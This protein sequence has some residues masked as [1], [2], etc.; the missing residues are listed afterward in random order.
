MRGNKYIHTY[1]RSG[2]DK[3]LTEYSRYTYNFASQ[4]KVITNIRVEFFSLNCPVTTG[5]CLDI[6]CVKKLSNLVWITGDMHN[7]KQWL[8]K[9]LKEGYSVHL[10]FV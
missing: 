5:I 8:R 2:W 3:H 6:S 9:H 10:I 4:A 7:E 1:C